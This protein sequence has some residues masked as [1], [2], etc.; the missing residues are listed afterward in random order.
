MPPRKKKV[1]TMK[2]TKPDRRRRE[3]AILQR[4]NIDI[5]LDM[6]GR[7]D[8]ESDRIGITRQALIKTALANFVQ[9]LEE[10]K[11]AK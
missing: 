1:A 3:R 8:N 2:K 7:L 4:V 6:L 10:R 9:A 5:P 11:S